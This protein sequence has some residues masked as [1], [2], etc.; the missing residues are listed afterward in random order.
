MFSTRLKDVAH[1][2][3]YKQLPGHPDNLICAV[4]VLESA[5]VAKTV[6]HNFIVEN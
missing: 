4:L 1:L 3:A 6:M 2:W 5:V